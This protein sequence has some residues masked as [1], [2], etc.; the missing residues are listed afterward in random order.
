MLAVVSGVALALAFEPVG[1]VGL[2]VVGPAGLMVATRGV[3][4]RQAAVIG[5]AFGAAL[6]LA[7]FAWLRAIG[8]DAYLALAASQTLFFTALGPALTVTGRL[9][10]WPL[11]AALWWTTVE[12]LR[13]T[14]PFSGMPWGRLSQGVADTPL[15]DA[16]PFFGSTG[17]SLI[18]AGTAGFVAWFVVGGWRRPL[19]GIAAILPLAAVIVL[20]AVAPFALTTVGEATV[21]AVQ[22]DVPGDGTDI[23]LDHRQVTRNQRDATLQLAEDVA[24][25]RQPRPDFVVWPEN[26]TAVDPFN[27]ED[28]RATIDAGVKGIGVPVLVGAIVDADQAG[29][30]LNQGIVWD[31]ETG[32]GD[33]YTKHNPVPFGEYIPW[34]TLFDGRQF[35]RL[36]EVGRDQQRGTR[37][38]PLRIDEIAVADAICF[39][40]AYDRVL[41]D[42]ILGGATMM[43]VQTSNALFVKTTQVDQQFDISRLRA[44]ETGRSVVIASTN[45][46]TGIV[47]PR[48]EVLAE[49][50]RQ[51]QAVVMASLPLVDTVTWAVLLGV[52]P[53]WT[54]SAAASGALL[55]G[56]ADYRRSRRRPHG[57]ALPVLD[58]APAAASV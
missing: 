1:L 50:P 11:W 9:R 36:Q 26:S 42:Q 48:G 52:W 41:Y 34:R 14:W 29:Y 6:S 38:T 51:T 16:L 53:A 46:L 55:I 31:P 44:A 45:G 13:I 24:A 8:P 40:I 30:I 28:V 57:A 43:T 33:R 19:L 27:Q 10:W 22:G 32:P 23:L 20:P 54:I 35:G 21:A 5:T 49:A 58:Q 25:G 2:L 3:A 47:S 7:L 18:L 56:L 4:L 37:T 15:V 17:V 39:D 12:S